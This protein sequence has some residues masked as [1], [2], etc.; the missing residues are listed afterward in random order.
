MT[1]PSRAMP[2]RRSR[3]P[4]SGIRNPNL[5]SRNSVAGFTIQI[6]GSSLGNPGPSGIGVR[7]TR[8]RAVLREISHSLGVRTSN[9]AEYEAL[10]RGLQEARRLQPGPVTIRTDSELLYYQMTGRYRVRNPEI[11]LLYAE[12][13]GLLSNQP[14]TRLELVRR[15]Q[16]HATDKLAK[17]GAEAGR[18][19][20]SHAC[21]A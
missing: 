21:Q 6:D 14:G 4:E 17:A 7:I 15:E 5:R 20:Q 9:Q 12:A 3:H 1:G 10:I 13:I 2:P 16:N 19:R 11:R 8:G 18:H